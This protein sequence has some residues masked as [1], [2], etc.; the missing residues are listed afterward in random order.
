VNGGISGADL[1]GYYGMQA[2]FDGHSVEFA[3]DLLECLWLVPSVQARSR[4]YQASIL[5]GDSSQAKAP[6]NSRRDHL[7]L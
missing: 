4:M 7:V 5:L 2:L 6:P 3:S 1:I